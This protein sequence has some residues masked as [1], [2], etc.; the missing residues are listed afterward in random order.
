[1]KPLPSYEEFI[2]ENASEALKYHLDN[3]IGISDSVFRIGS[4][5]YRELFE[6]V[7]KYWDSNN[8]ILNDKEAWMAKHL[9][10]GKKAKYKS[11]GKWI[12]VHLDEPTRGGNKKFFVYHNSGKKDDDGNIIAKK[13]EWGDPKLSIKNDDPSAAASFWSRQQCDTKERMNPEMPGFWACYAPSLF[14]K[15]LDLQSDKPW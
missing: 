13:I 7:K 5:G 4:D 14:S 10:I 8:I 15:Q 6:E 12:D 1:M 3:N 9:E 11:N 2:N